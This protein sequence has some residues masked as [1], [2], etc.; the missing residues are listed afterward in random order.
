VGAIFRRRREEL[1]ASATISDS[2]SCVELLTCL[3][4]ARDANRAGNKPRGPQ[5]TDPV[6]PGGPGVTVGSDTIRSRRDK[7]QAE[8]VVKNVVNVR[9]V[10]RLP[11]LPPHLT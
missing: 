5:G 8:A 2:A 10:N 1:P 11:T 6:R 9:V 4:M 7:R 3:E